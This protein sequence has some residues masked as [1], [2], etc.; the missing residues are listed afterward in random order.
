MNETTC[1]VLCF[2]IKK[3]REAGIKVSFSDYFDF[4][5][6]FIKRFESKSTFDSLCEYLHNGEGKEIT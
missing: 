3:L 2:M 6:E 4:R 5:D 1:L